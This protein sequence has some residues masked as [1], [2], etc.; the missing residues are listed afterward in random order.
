MRKG[1]SMESPPPHANPPP[2]R[3]PGG[4]QREER[5]E[6]PFP[7][8]IRGVD[9]QGK[10][11]GLETVLDY[12]SA[13]EFALGLPRR[14]VPGARVFAVVRLSLAP[15]AVPA[16]RIALRGIIRQVAR[17]WAGQYATTV[18]ITRHRFL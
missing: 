18:Q 6:E 2:E 4:A 5:L 13:H 8:L 14:L 16:P 17:R 10:T 3:P 7:I 11:V 1:I 9:A 12:I 15:P